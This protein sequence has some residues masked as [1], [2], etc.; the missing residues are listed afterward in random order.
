VG[1]R[2]GGWDRLQTD[3]AAGPTVHTARL[4]RL[5]WLRGGTGR[6]P[7]LPAHWEADRAGGA[8]RPYRLMPRH[9]GQQWQ[10]CDQWQRGHGWR[11]R[12]HHLQQQQVRY[13]VTLVSFLDP[14]VRSYTSVLILFAAVCGRGGPISQWL[15]K[16]KVTNNSDYD[17]DTYVCNTL[18]NLALET[19]ATKF[20]QK[21][22]RVHRTPVCCFSAV[23]TFRFS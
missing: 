11:H 5:R 17:D 8:G 6:L 4:S 10:D 20:R 9:A 21:F 3:A 13:P 7:A 2:R 22:T 14:W 18:Y 15:V 16:R 23:R 1:R 19:F 12:Q